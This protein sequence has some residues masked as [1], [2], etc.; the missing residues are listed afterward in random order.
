MAH[1]YLKAMRVSAALRH[2]LQTVQTRGEF[3]EALQEISDRGP[4]VGS[5]TDLPDM[6]IAVPAGPVEHW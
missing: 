2:R 3:H 1:W 6:H 5:R 4:A